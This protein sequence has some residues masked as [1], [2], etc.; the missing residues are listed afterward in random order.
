M[1]EDHTTIVIPV[2]RD[3]YL[4]DLFVSLDNL[5][6]D[7]DTTALFIYVDGDLRLFEKVREFVRQSKFKEK[8]CVYRKKG[9][10]N[11]SHMPS[12]RRRIGEIHKEIGTYLSDN[13]FVFLIEDDTIVPVDALQVLLK[14]IWSYP[15]TGFTSGI[16]LGRWGFTH[17]G[18]W[19]VD[20]II[21]TQRITSIKD[22]E[23]EDLQGVDA[24]GLYC[25]LTRRINYING[26]FKPFEKILGPDFTF[27]LDLRRKGFMNYV[28]KYVKC[29]H[30][31]PKEDID[32]TNSEIIQVR[33]DKMDGSKLGWEMRTL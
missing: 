5:L 15:N 22:S 12:R 18:A 7:I 13:E 19:N 24:A 1:T 23:I 9:L 10:P 30:K 6:C 14:D 20:D 27:G 11:I 28:N 8:L 31:T 16:A 17:I 25:C 3:R 32:F 26:D 29:I 21:N 2:S 33:F 4:K